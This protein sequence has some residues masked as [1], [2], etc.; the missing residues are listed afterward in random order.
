[1]AKIKISEWQK[2]FN[3]GTYDAPY[4]KTQIEAGWYDWFCRDSSLANK[5]KKMGQIIKEI[6]DGGKVDLEKNTIFFKNNCP[7]TGPLYDEFRIC[8]LETNDAL[9][10]IQIDCCRSDCKYTVYGL[11]QWDKPIF[12]TD[13]KKELLSW[14]NSK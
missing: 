5:T 10:T 14:L 3:T 7:L 11:G 2:A 12:K 1:M 6:K 4:V 8:D 13:S 9:F